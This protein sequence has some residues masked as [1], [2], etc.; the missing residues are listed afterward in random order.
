ME[1]LIANLILPWFGGSASVWLACLV[2]FQLAL[3]GEYLLAHLLARPLHDPGDPL[4]GLSVSN[5]VL[6]AE[7]TCFFRDPLLKDAKAIAV[8]QEL[9]PWTED[10]SNLWKV[11]D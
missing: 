11:L 10:Y 2:F 3:L 1:P 6:A 9:R 8:P 4:Y 7:D 5:W